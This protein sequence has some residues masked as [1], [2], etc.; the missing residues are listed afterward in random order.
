M[1]RG[2][3]KSTVRCCSM[4][5]WVPSAATSFCPRTRRSQSRCGSCF[6]HAFDALNI[7]SEAGNYVAGKQCGKT[8]LLDVL[9]CFGAASVADREHQRIPNFSRH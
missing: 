3:F 1:S 8:T 5:R 4:R 2:L 6:C 9:R 7:F